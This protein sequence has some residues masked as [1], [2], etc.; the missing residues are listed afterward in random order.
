MDPPS[1]PQWLARD[2]NEDTKGHSS[3]ACGKT[4][5]IIKLE[6]HLSRMSAHQDLSLAHHG[7]QFLL[8]TKEMK[9]K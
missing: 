7:P 6:F 4:T 8:M 2:E 9:S 5:E 3:N 1:S